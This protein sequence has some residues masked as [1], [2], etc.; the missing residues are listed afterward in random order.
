MSLPALLR[1][2][3]SDWAT[4]TGKRRG[5][6]RRPARGPRRSTT[7]RRRAPRSEPA[8]SCRPVRSGSRRAARSGQCRLPEGSTGR[9]RGHG[10]PIQSLA[11][12]PQPGGSA[13][14]RNVDTNSAPGQAPSGTEERPDTVASAPLANERTRRS[15]RPRPP[16]GPAPPQNFGGA[17]CK[18]GNPR[19]AETANESA[20]DRALER[21]RAS[22]SKARWGPGAR[23]QSGEL[24]GRKHSC[25]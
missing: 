12:A 25:V 18:W 15:A 6:T 10:A 16:G 23:R 21:V 8:R 13:R 11:G 24:G 20:L 19:S 7:D 1:T 2:N 22:M 17:G 14:H 5:L 3:T 9:T 4:R